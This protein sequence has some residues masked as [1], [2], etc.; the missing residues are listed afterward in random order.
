MALL[1]YTTKISA[2]K[3]VGEIQKALAKAGA[4]SILSEYNGSG[5][6]TAMSFRMNI[7]DAQ[8]GFRLPA[9]WKPVLYILQ[10]DRS[11]P[12]NLKTEEQAIRVS[13]R[14]IKDW[15]EAQLAI[16]ATQMVK[17]EQAFLPYMLNA[18]GSTVYEMF[19]NNPQFLLGEGRG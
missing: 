18:G 1:N 11:V 12:R 3:T 13:W 2:D 9:D 15:V 10:H 14:I 6:V 5:M 17:P 7:K 19:A 8:I 4:N 16:I